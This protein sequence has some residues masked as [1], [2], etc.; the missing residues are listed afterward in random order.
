MIPKRIVCEALFCYKAGNPATLMK[1]APHRP[2][3]ITRLHHATARQAFLVLCS[4]LCPVSSVFPQGSLTP[5][6]APAP[7]MKTLDQVEP[8]VPINA[9]NTPGDA[10]SVFRISQPGS[11]YLTGNVTG[12]SGKSGIEIAS[13]NVTIDLMGYTLQGVTG[14]LDG[15]TNASSRTKLTV[16]NGVVTGFSQ[17]GVDL[18]TGVGTLVEQVHASNNG[19]IG[20]KVHLSSVVRASTAAGNDIGI[21][22]SASSTVIGCTAYAN[23]S[24]GISVGSALVSDCA[25]YQN[26]G[27]GI[28]AQSG[29]TVTN[30]TAQSNAGVG[31]SGGPGSIS[32]VTLTNCTASDNTGDGISVGTGSTLNNCTAKD[33]AGTYGI[34]AG[35]GSTL[36]SCTAYSNDVEF[37]IRVDL[38]S[39]VT[40]CTA[41][42]NNSSAAASY[43]IFAMEE[44][45]ISNCTASGNTN[46]NATFDAG[47]GIF[48]GPSSTIKDC[49][50]TEN[51]GDGIQMNQDSRVIGNLCDSNGLGAGD[52]AGIH[53]ITA[54]GG[55]RIE[56]N[57]VSD[58]DRGLDVDSTGNLIIKNSASGSGANNYSIVASNSNA[59]VLTPGANF[60]STDPWANFSY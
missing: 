3:L 59:Q 4:V 29:A 51:K 20:I 50:A 57:N 41:S 1:T 17:D 15:I 49:T 42:E 48:A 8:R 2:P 23:S 9:T 53:A 24:I 11:Y 43:G 60:V 36:N 54:N 22:T 13:N 34:F 47:V 39:T 58:G 56:G 5:P 10:D 28:Q 14:S 38:R 40:N 45:T 37:G 35:A 21:L 26:F 55:S 31:I 46:S 33:N 30:S 7:T 32:S 27:D 44:G 16:R 19:L 18:S 52:G 12:E 25:T 6:G